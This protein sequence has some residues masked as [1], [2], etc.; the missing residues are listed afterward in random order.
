M[1]DKLNLLLKISQKNS[2]VK[3]ILL[4][5]DFIPYLLTFLCSFMPVARNVLL[6]H[7]LE[8]LIQEWGGGEREGSEG[9]VAPAARCFTLKL[10]LHSFS[11]SEA[12][13]RFPRPVPHS[14]LLFSSSWSLHPRPWHWLYLHTMPGIPTLEGK[15]HHS[16]RTRPG[17]AGWHKTDLE[18]KSLSLYY[19]PLSSGKAIQGRA[20]SLSPTTCIKD[21]TSY[22]DLMLHPP[23]WLLP[24]TA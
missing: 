16:L 1:K 23:S 5:L 3:V 24:V 2:I 6:T 8:L 9:S 19:R 7:H 22:V 18:Q 14:H 10:F 21:P 15:V 13:K 17:F 20:S 4:T 12:S 11:D